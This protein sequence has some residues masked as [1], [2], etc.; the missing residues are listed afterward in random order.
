MTKTSRKSTTRRSKADPSPYPPGWSRKRVQA[1]I[2]HYENQSDDEAIAEANAAYA[3]VKT[4]MVQVPVDL[5]PEVE[6][7]LAKRRG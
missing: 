7:L 3:A 5:V 2:E 6:R 4:T 1:V